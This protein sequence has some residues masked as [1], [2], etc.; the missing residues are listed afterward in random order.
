MMGWSLLLALSLAAPSPHAGVG[1]ETRSG[2]HMLQFV[3]EQL[4]FEP[5]DCVVHRWRMDYSDDDYEGAEDAAGTCGEEDLQY[6]AR[7]R[8]LESIT[9]D[10]PETVDFLS[11]GWTEY[12]ANSRFALLV[13]MVSPD[14]ALHPPGL[15]ISVYPTTTGDLAS[16]DADDGSEHLEFAGDLVFGRTDGMSTHGIAERYPSSDYVIIGQE[17]FCIRGRRLPALMEELQRQFDRDYRQGFPAFPTAN[18]QA[19]SP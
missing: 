4:S 3:G 19:A 13:V 17:A 14:G 7:Y 2:W 16:C 5:M 11:S 1:H 9:G 6:R 10:A 18:R 15:A 12:Y 8:V